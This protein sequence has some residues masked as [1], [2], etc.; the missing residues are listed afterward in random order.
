MNEYL[1]ELMCILAIMVWLIRRY[2]FAR[3]SAVFLE[4]GNSSGLGSFRKREGESHI[5]HT[6][7]VSYFKHGSSGAEDG[8][9]TPDEDYDYKALRKKILETWGQSTPEGNGEE[10]NTSPDTTS[11]DSSIGRKAQD[12][13][14][15]N[16]A[17]VQDP[18]P[19]KRRNVSEPETAPA[20]KREYEPARVKTVP[21]IKTPLPERKMPDKAKAHVKKKIAEPAQMEASSNPD[22]EGLIPRCTAMDGIRCSFRA[23]QGKGRME[24]P[25][26]IDRPCCRAFWGGLWILSKK[27]Y[28][29]KSS[30]NA[31]VRRFI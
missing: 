14:S 23:S 27:R 1:I 5:D 15:Q 20:P 18:E 30:G 4:N 31:A 29:A 24:I 8:L 21:E 13:S 28:M 26:I 16:E 22:S 19:V 7:H 9:G 25:Q 3:L 17:P 12:E 2:P 11:P 6:V 10:D